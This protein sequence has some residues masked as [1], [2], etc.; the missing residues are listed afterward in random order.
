MGSGHSPS[1]PPEHTLRPKKLQGEPSS[2]WAHT[3][4]QTAGVPDTENHTPALSTLTVL[5]SA[6]AHPCPLT[7]VCKCT[8]TR[9]CKQAWR[10]ELRAWACGET[11]APSSPPT[12][13]PFPLGG[14]RAADA[15][16]AQPGP[17]R[18]TDAGSPLSPRSPPRAP[19]LWPRA[20]PASHS[21]Q[22]HQ[23]MPSAKCPLRGQ[24]ATFAPDFWPRGG[25]IA[26]QG[27]LLSLPG[28]EEEDTKPTCSRGRSA[29]AWSWPTPPPASPQAP[30]PWAPTASVSQSCP[31]PHALPPAQPREGQRWPLSP[32]QAFDITEA[33]GGSVQ[34]L[35]LGG[36]SGHR[37][38]GH[39]QSKLHG[40]RCCPLIFADRARP[41]PCLNPLTAQATVPPST[42]A[43]DTRR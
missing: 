38:S 32:D 7:R 17:P 15:V 40:S 39:G 29:A 13:G 1:P 43:H 20:R 12:P 11:W 33:A 28:W 23:Q 34:Q 21:S 9:Q 19:A 2:H 37:H 24:R 30:S 6:H 27:L 22:H 35:R 4:R 42:T 10:A 3:M 31:G 41:W 18:A 8:H 26:T 16:S 5:T 36:P 25:G 14:G